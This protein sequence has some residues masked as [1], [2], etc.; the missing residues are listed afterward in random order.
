MTV[1]PHQAFEGTKSLVVLVSDTL[2]QE[3]RETSLS[4]V[5]LMLMLVLMLMLMLMLVLMLMLMLGFCSPFLFQLE[6]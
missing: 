1:S 4:G 2:T 5:Q 6:T 3:N